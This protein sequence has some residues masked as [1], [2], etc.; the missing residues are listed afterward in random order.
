MDEGRRDAVVTGMEL[1]LE[2]LMF[3]NKYMK[4]L[5]SAVLAC[6]A[7]AFPGAV[8]A[9]TSAEIIVTGNIGGSCS[10]EGA[11]LKFVHVPADDALRVLSTATWSSTSAY[12]TFFLSNLV[13]DT[14][15]AEPGGNQYS[16]GLT[17]AFNAATSSAFGSP[18]PS[19]SSTSQNGDG[20]LIPGIPFNGPVEIVAE[21]IETS[22][23]IL[24]PG[25]Y[26]LSA[27]ASCVIP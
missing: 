6:G 18:G 14:P 25:D 13:Y 16:A 5:L 4:H 26:R 3:V 17:V 11:R 15:T 27:T 12:T 8:I 21:I 10:V 7:C 23:A 9:E 20:S 19:F 22:Q 1:V 2:T 24:P